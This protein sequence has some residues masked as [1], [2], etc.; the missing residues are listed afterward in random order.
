MTR[1]IARRMVA[2]AGILVLV[3]FAV[4]VMIASVPGDPAAILAGENAT[5]EQVA[6][7]RSHLGLDQPL[8]ER[9]L[10]WLGH[11]LQGDLGNSL[12]SGEAITSA[13]ASP[14]AVTTALVTVTIVLST[15]LGLAMGIVAVTAKWRWVDRV[16]SAVSALGIA[17]PS[18][19]AGLILVSVL[20]VSHNWFP[21]VGYVPLWEDPGQWIMHLIL[22]SI[23]LGTL[24]AAEIAL[25]VRDSMATEL[26]RDYVQVARAK[27]LSESV[28]IARHVLK[29]AAI[30]V[31]T[32]F[33]YRA[34]QLVG[35]AIAVE[36]VFALPGLGQIA[37]TSTLTRD[38]NMLLGMVVVTTVAV[39]VINLLVDISYGYFNPKVRS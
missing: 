26:R 16:I 18:F 22:P 10:S 17:V 36:V 12:R 32:V 25:Q 3:S 28:I 35:G 38:V 13:L 4:F 1:M 8:V 29:N 5:P 15:V 11:A 31:L 7:L 2:A 23:A 21:A 33:G 27:G 19:W 34:G 9:Y 30:P 20:A 24:P 6:E 39:V 37:V 14:I